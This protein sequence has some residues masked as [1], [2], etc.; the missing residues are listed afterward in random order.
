M[1]KLMD[2]ELIL[3]L[4]EESM[5]V[6]GKMGACMVT[7]FILGQMAEN[8]K[9]ITLKIREMEKVS[10]LGLM[11]RSTTVGGKTGSNMER[12]LSLIL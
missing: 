4:M 2:K 10:L 9:E 12:E 3:G 11:E 7:V 8:L 5:S 6:N 1:I